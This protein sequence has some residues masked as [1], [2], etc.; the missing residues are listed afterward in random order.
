MA[1]M[2]K[3]IATQYLDYDPETGLFRWKVDVSRIAKQ[4]SIAGHLSGKGYRAI[5]FQGKSYLSHRL[6]WLIVYGE[7]PP[8][9]IDHIN[10]VPDDNRIANLRSIPQSL[11]VQNLRRARADNTIGFLGVTR[12][13]KRF[14]ARIWVAGKSKRYGCYDTPEEAHEAYLKVKRE[15]HKGCTI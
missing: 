8:Y 10:G 15:L 7:W 5:S 12:A 4:G 6:A 3:E 2:N 13:G 11:N 1:E 9:G 14:S